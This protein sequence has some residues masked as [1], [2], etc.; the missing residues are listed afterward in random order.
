MI[1]KILSML[2]ITFFV[3]Y[4]QSDKIKETIRTVTNLNITLPSEGAEIAG[5]QLSV[6]KYE[7]E[8]L[9]ENF[10]PLKKNDFG[11]FKIIRKPDD[12]E[13]KKLTQGGRGTIV[14]GYIKAK[15]YKPG[16]YIIKTSYSG[17]GEIGVA[18]VDRYYKVIVNYPTFA[19]AK[20]LDS[21]Y[22]IG[23]KGLFSIAVNEFNDA[24]L[25]SYKVY[26]IDKNGTK[27][28]LFSDNKPL[29]DLGK[30][31]QLN[32]LNKTIQ[33]EGFYDN[34][35]YEFY[36]IDGQIKKSVWQTEILPID[37]LVEFNNWA[38][39]DEEYCVLDVA[40]NT[41]FNPLTFYYLYAQ[42]KDVNF[43]ALT[44]ECNDLVVEATPNN[45]LAGE[46]E[47]SQSG[48][49]LSI[50]L[51]INPKFVTGIGSQRAQLVSLNFNFRTQFGEVS[52]TYKAKVFKSK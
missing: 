17:K 23:E 9:D 38:A 47:V 28:E 37:A 16:N 40:T 45:F 1:R 43:I 42:S 14:F 13:F 24:S 52:R 44:P 2:F 6:I 33:I 5:N 21:I 50:R 4:G 11:E 48:A 20:T 51:N 46:P 18:S 39:S 34:R 27:I 19:S 25:Y 41:L 7:I 26:E 36:D 49:F 10:K 3:L 32:Y 15:F 8:L 22:Y 12:Q 35:V 30:I 29:V 31:I